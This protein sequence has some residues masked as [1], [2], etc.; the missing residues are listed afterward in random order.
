M[1]TMTQ[2]YTRTDIRRVLEQFQADLL[3]LAVRTQAMDSSHA[4]ECGNDVYLMAREECLSL[5]HI[6]LRD[7]YGNLVRAYKY[8]IHRE[9]HL[10]T[11]RPG[12]NGWPCLPNGTLNVLVRP[13]NQQS[14][15]K[16]QQSGELNLSWGLSS[17]STD[18]SGMRNEKSRLYSSQ[19]YG[20]QRDSFV[21]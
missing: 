9:S 21:I 4:Q 3:M 19:R 2:T 6:Q 7:P 12:C 11:Q 15:Q 20:L 1:V 13:S 10:S 17:L 8:T 18:Y 14:L 16:L 5:I